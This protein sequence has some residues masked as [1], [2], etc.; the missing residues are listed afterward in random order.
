MSISS[1]QYERKKQEFIQSL[2]KK[3]IQPNNFELNKML[4]EYFDNHVMGMPYYAPIKQEPYEAS[5]KD[6]YN[7]NFQTFKEDIETIYQADI[8]AN[9]KAVAMQEY[10][11]TEKIKVMNALSKLQLRIENISEALKSSSHAKQYVQVF[12]DLYGVEFYGD[13]KRNI[14]YT[15]SFVDLLQKKVY[16]DKT[17]SKINKIL[18]ENALIELNGFTQF[19][20]YNTQGDIEK[21]LNDTLD[22]VYILSAKSSNN[23]EKYIQLDVDLCKLVT[24]N[25]V[26]FSY[27]STKAMPCELYLSDDGENYIAVYDVTNRDYVEWNF[28]AKTARYIRIICRKAEPD[29]I[30]TISGGDIIAYDYNFL[31]KNISI[32]KEEFEPKSIF[33]SKVIDFDDLVSTIRLDA[34]DMIYNHTRIDYFIGFERSR[35]GTNQRYHAVDVTSNDFEDTL[36]FNE[37]ANECDVVLDLDGNITDTSIN[38]HFPG[39][40]NPDKTDELIATVYTPDKTFK[41]TVFRGD[42]ASKDW[43]FELTEKDIAGATKI[44]YHIFVPESHKGCCKNAEIKWKASVVHPSVEEESVRIIPNPLKVGWDAIENHKDYKLFMFEKRHKIL[45]AHLKEFGTQGAVLSKLYKLY[46]LPDG[47]NRNSVKV[48]AGYNM[49]HVKRYNRKAGDN[50]DDNFSIAS[51][52]FSRHV[53]KCNMTHMFMDCENYDHFHIQTN[54]LY[55]MTQYVSLESSQNL[56]DNFIKVTDTSYTVEADAEIRV[57]LNGYEVTPIDKDRYSFALKK[58]VNKVQIALYCP[59]KNAT[60]KFLYHN[61]NFKALTNDVFGC[62]PMKYTNNTILDR[63]VGDTYEYYTIKDNWIYVKCDPDMMIKSDL[64]D[65]G[66]FCSYYCLREDMRDYFSDGHLRFRIMAVFHSD[67]RNVSPELCNF[68]LTGR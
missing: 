19:S 4:T 21:I 40:S 29:G 25:M 14:P 60:T 11:D 16:T 24:F 59:S 46:E 57:F 18:I 6:G 13:T 15:T 56:F 32:A 67:D 66:Y 35:L 34:T 52:D 68:R 10:Y 55:V 28:N 49:W 65:M 38:V 44:V 7:H 39:R 2:C 3:G 36:H 5:S 51:G 12:D 62:T 63:M 43:T 8:Q 20:E 23:E 1:I 47:V 9:N 41:I 48:T 27:S 30:D 33:V 53:A 64:E 54:V 26:S 17:N 42:F 61:L 45:N 50:N 22:E 37:D 31:F 58:G